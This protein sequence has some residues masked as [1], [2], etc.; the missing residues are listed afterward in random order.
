MLANTTRLVLATALA[1]GGTLAMQAPASAA[2]SCLLGKWKL[3]QFT[4]TA[5]GE[6]IDVTGQGAEGMRL[7]VGKNSVT[8]NFTKA[9]K[10]VTTGTEAGKPLTVETQYKK[11]LTMKSSFKGTKTGTLTLKPK[12]ASGSA[13]GTVS[14]GGKKTPAYKLAKKYRGGEYEPIAV[15]VS[16]F[17]CSG[18]TKKTKKATATLKITYTISDPNGTAVGTLSFKR[19]S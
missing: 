7:T 14:F 12:T 5:K 3:T 15:P 2:K 13:T 4:M 8:Y 18:K 1:A 6:N 17:D 11:S 10:L 19:S 9:K 16:A